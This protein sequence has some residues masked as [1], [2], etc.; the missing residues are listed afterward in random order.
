[1]SEHKAH[2]PLRSRNTHEMTMCVV[3]LLMCV[4][5]CM[6]VLPP[7]APCLERMCACACVSCADCAHVCVSEG[8]YNAGQAIFSA[9]D[10]SILLQR[11]CADIPPCACALAQDAVSVAKLRTGGSMTREGG[12]H[13]QSVAC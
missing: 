6:C 4:H 13:A 9:Q 1:M 3:Q 10:P 5:V 8:S 12:M 2:T 7:C 11:R